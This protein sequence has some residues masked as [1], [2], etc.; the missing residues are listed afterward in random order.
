[1]RLFRQRR[2]E[3][4]GEVTT[5]VAGEFV[6]VARGERARLAPFQAR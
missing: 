4:W 3:T 2:G 5:Q 6:A 1:M